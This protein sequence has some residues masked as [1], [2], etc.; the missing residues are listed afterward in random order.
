MTPFLDAK[1]LPFLMIN[2][3]RGVEVRRRAAGQRQSGLETL[4]R[5]NTSCQNVPLQASE[6]NAIP[7]CLCGCVRACVCVFLNCLRQNRELRD[8]REEG[9][10]KKTSTEKCADHRA[11]CRFTHWASILIFTQDF[12]GAHRNRKQLRLILVFI[13]P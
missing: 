6:R 10:K 1:A 7:V 4:R 11:Q 2:T 9:G 3:R 13:P 5:F 12:L 8:R